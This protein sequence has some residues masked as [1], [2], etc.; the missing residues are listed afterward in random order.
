MH[1]RAARI[2]LALV[3]AL[4]CRSG[5]TP[6]WHALSGAVTLHSAEALAPAAERVCAFASKLEEGEVRAVCPFVY[7]SG[8]LR[9][10]RRGLDLDAG[11]LVD[12]GSMGD[13]E[14]A[15]GRVA[16]FLAG[17]L[18]AAREERGRTF[19]FL[20]GFDPG[21]AE[22][23][24]VLSS[25]AADL[26]AARA[27]SAASTDPHCYLVPLGSP[28]G[29]LV[30]NRLFRN[31]LPMGG[32]VKYA[33][34][35]DV[36]RYSP[37]EEA[38]VK[39]ITLQLFFL[40]EIAGRRYVLSPVYRKGCRIMVPQAAAF[41]CLFAD[42]RG[43]LL[44]KG[45]LDPYPPGLVAFEALTQMYGGML[46]SWGAGEKLKC[47]KRAHQ[48]FDLLGGKIGDERRARFETVLARYLGNDA[49]ADAAGFYEL[50]AA[51]LAYVARR[52]GTGPLDGAFAAQFRRLGGSLDRLSAAFPQARE[53]LAGCASANAAVLRLLERGGG[54]AE[55]AAR[56]GVSAAAGRRL[57]AALIEDADLDFLLRTV[58]ETLAGCGVAQSVSLVTDDTR[59]FGQTIEIGVVPRE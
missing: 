27:L 4:P 38:G 40:A 48:V 19:L 21:S 57:E 41:N 36:V 39:Q 45:L 51:A 58:A 5:A 35:S 31:I 43:A 18:A 33:F 8:F 20:S 13:D 24:A 56:L 54:S 12:L 23:R 50:P 29:V 14:A 25:L 28:G 16:R 49:Y 6:R 22:G 37:A 46:S 30:P 3:L 11:L 10:N 59:P 42:R 7:G 52:G 32:N 1:R 15:A 17:T 47:L 53:E 26:Q 55:F 44:M 9:G 34:L 2:V